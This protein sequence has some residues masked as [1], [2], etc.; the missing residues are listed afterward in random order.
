MA[1]FDGRAFERANGAVLY[2][3]EKATKTARLALAFGVVVSAKGSRALLVSL[4][5]AHGLDPDSAL[6]ESIRVAQEA[7]DHWAVQGVMA[8]TLAAVEDEHI[9]WWEGADGVLACRIWTT[10]RLPNPTIELRGEV[11]DRDGKLVPP[12]PEPVLA[13]H[14]SF[15]FFRLGQAT[16]D[17]VDAF[18]NYYLALEAILSTIEPMPLR[19]DGRPAEQETKWLN[20]ALPK[21]ATLVDFRKYAAPGASGD[22]ID[23][24]RADIYADARTRTFHAKTGAAVLLPHDAATRNALQDSMLRL[25]QLYLDLAQEVLGFRFL[26]GVR[27][28]P[29]AFRAM[30]SGLAIKQF[31]ASSEAVEED[32]AKEGRSPVTLTYFDATHAS[33]L[34]D[35]YHVVYVGTLPTHE[36]PSG[37]IRQLGAAMADGRIAIYEDLEG[38]LNIGGLGCVQYV[39]A[40]AGQDPRALDTRYLS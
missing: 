9:V 10:M 39:I 16:T 23:A 20:R 35:E 36:W 15:R 33:A 3:Q 13:W 19:Q 27:L 22:P 38:E 26:G 12:T 21:A 30:V 4:V 8:R 2:L 1:A 7:L 25:R 11:R 14:P 37:L 5:A 28:A 24:V 34:D 17:L 40:V 29:A 18:R 6:N 32:A 31:Y